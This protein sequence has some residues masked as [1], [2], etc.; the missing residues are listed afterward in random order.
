MRLDDVADVV[1]VTVGHREAQRGV[2]GAHLVEL[3]GRH[4]VGV[5]AAVRELR[6]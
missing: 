2:L 4:V 1:V 3:V 6:C 5:R